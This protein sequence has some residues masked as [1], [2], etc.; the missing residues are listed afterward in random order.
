MSTESA[1]RTGAGDRIPSSGGQLLHF[2]E[3]RFFGPF[4]WKTIRVTS[5]VVLILVLGGAILELVF[6]RHAHGSRSAPA[7]AARIP[8]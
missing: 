5:L 1:Q 6:W 8:S 7:T 2:A 3:P 4:R